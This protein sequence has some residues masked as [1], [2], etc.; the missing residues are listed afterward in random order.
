MRIESE[1]RDLD[2]DTIIRHLQSNIELT[3]FQLRVKDPIT[4]RW[5]DC[6]LSL[7]YKRG[8][9]KFYLSHE[10]GYPG[11]EKGTTV[12]TITANWLSEDMP[13]ISKALKGL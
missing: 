11:Q 4:H 12:K 3:V 13:K 7:Q 1:R 6:W 8:R 9:I 10:R 2:L 5:T